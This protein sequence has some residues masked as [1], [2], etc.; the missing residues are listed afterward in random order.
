MIDITPLAPGV[1]VVTDDGTITI[2]RRS[3][4]RLWR[5]REVQLGQIVPFD[6]PISCPTPRIVRDCSVE[7]VPSASVVAQTIF[8][9][10]RNPALSH[11]PGLPSMDRSTEAQGPLLCGIAP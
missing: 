9:G 3:P 8:C 5:C 2:S 10:R 1:L 4:A 11:A 7:E 6:T